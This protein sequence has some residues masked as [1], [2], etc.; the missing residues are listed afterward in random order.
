M[1]KN[2]VEVNIQTPSENFLVQLPLTGHE[3]TDALILDSA[4]EEAHQILKRYYKEREWT[5]DKSNTG[6][7]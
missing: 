3:Y 1:L 6:G 7:N 5:L 4:F 2:V